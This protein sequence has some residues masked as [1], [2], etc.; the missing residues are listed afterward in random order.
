MRHFFVLALLVFMVSPCFSQSRAGERFKA[1]SDAM[2]RTLEASNA[3]LEN[4]NQDAGAAES[5]KTYLRYRRRYESLSHALKVSESRMDLYF[6]TNDKPDVIIE[7]RDKYE[8]Y[9]KQLEDVKSEYDNWLRN[10]N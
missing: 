2:G 10:V 7:E 1:L 4:Y 8:N 3:N 5:M 6:R 9:V